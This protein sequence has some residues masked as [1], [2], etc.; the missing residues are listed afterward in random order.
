ME[1]LYELRRGFVVKRRVKGGHCLCSSGTFFVGAV[2]AKILS[3]FDL[4]LFP[5]IWVVSYYYC[6]FRNSR[7]IPLVF[8]CLFLNGSV[9][10]EATA[11]FVPAG[12]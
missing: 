6:Y 5:F 9:F 8:D 11:C 7:K 12:N 10:T 1:K 4:N 2:T 3:A